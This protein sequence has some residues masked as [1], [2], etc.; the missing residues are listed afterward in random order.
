MK[1]YQYR[2]SIEELYALSNGGKEFKTM[3]TLSDITKWAAS[4]GDNDIQGKVVGENFLDFLL[5]DLGS[6][7]NIYEVTPATEDQDI[8][9]N[10]DVFVKAIDANSNKKITVRI[11]YKWFA[12]SSAKIKSEHISGMKNIVNRGDC[13][14]T[15]VG[16]VTNVY[17]S[18]L[19]REVKLFPWL[20]ITAEQY[21]PLVNGTFFKR[22]IKWVNDGKTQWEN[23]RKK[24]LKNVKAKTPYPHQVEMRADADKQ[25]GTNMVFPGGG[26]TDD[27]A[28]N[29]SYDFKNKE[30]KNA[31]AVFPTLAL[32]DQNCREHLL[33]LKK[34]FGNS[35][36]II[37]FSS[38]KTW[39]IETDYGFP[40]INLQIGNQ[41]DF[42]KYCEMC[43]DPMTLTYTIGTYAGM[44]GYVKRFIESTLLHNW[45]YDEAA[46]LIPGQQA[47]RLEGL[48]D[49]S[50]LFKSF[51]DL[52][53]Y[54][55]T[56]GGSMKYWDAVNLSS[57]DPK[58]VAFGNEHYFGSYT[59]KGPYTIQ[60]GVAN[61]II[62]D[63]EILLLSYDNNEVKTELGE[64]YIEDD[65]NMI[66]AYCLT[67][68]NSEVSKIYGNAKTIAYMNSA[69]NC[70]P[71]ANILKNYRPS[72][73]YGSIVG[74]T[75][76][77]DRQK[78]LKAFAN[79]RLKE[80]SIL[81]YIILSLGI[82]ENSANGVFMSRNMNDRYLAHSINRS[83]RR[84]PDDLPMVPLVNKPV[85]Y[86]GFGIDKNDHSS[87]LESELFQQQIYKMLNMGIS[88][89][90][91][92]IDGQSKHKDDKGINKGQFI[93]KNVVTLSGDEILQKKVEDL[94]EVQRLELE[95]KGFK[96][97]VTALDNVDDEDESLE[98]LRKAIQNG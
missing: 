18:G 33:I 85:G 57:Y 80:A 19:P 48:E 95:R 44:S 89:K 84:H 7:F 67:R 25:F 23:R 9:E 63:I 74:A 65:P 82:S 16:I 46:S 15:E 36:Q 45:Y 52:V 49:E 8:K 88:P 50:R 14:P 13:K 34:E 43:R 6:A 68:F 32:A 20:K 76:T 3:S 73:F 35:L 71:T 96:L 27:Q 97:F 31:V 38:Q 90:I 28:Y 70:D 98:I 66:D 40:V 2:S 29:I 51:K 86:V 26:K 12:D 60:Y 17:D 11:N 39:Q 58:A 37:N 83:T 41:E 59:G 92:I 54:Q 69:A 10:F 87:L 94:I 24:S 42:V 78:I 62:A 61:H 30:I 47:H 72:G 4:F 64:S 91:T 5:I 81:N 79:P 77:T 56:T 53:E 1:K 55:H 93:S 21:E 22:F 75:K